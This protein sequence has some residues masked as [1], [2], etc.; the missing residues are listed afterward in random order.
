MRGSCCSSPRDVLFDCLNSATEMKMLWTCHLS[1][2][3]KKTQ[4]RK[5][6]KMAKLPGLR[7]IKDSDVEK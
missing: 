2:S 4:K 1:L 5:D 6:V 3:E 7:N